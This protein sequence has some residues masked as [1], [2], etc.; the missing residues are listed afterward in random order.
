ML[1]RINLEARAEPGT[2][3][4]YQI[5]PKTREFVVEEVEHMCMAKTIDFA[6]F[7]WAS[8]VVIVSKHDESNVL[9]INY[10]KLHAVIIRNTYLRSRMDESI[11]FLKDATVLSRMDASWRH[12]QM[13]VAE[14]DEDK[15]TFT[16]QAGTYPFSQMPFWLMNALQRFSVH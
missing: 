12:W 6:P 10:R 16:S 14:E 1:H 9:C 11:V 5:E 3:L 4:L 2:Q 7:A 13:P 8:P 15:S